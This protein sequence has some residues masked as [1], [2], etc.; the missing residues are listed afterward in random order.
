MLVDALMNTDVVTVT[1]DHTVLRAA[2][3]MKERNVGA[4]VVVDERNRPV[5]LL[6]DRDISVNVVAVGR[7]LETPVDEVMSRPVHTVPVN[8]L[9]F[10]LLRDMA[11]RHVHRIPVVNRYKKLVGIVS[12]DDAM[13]LLTTELSNVAEV[14]AQSSRALSD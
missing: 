13:L 11:Q 6:T 14:F 8:T 9:I 12:V 5:G 10:D 3:L 2:R 7:S 1:G 4:V